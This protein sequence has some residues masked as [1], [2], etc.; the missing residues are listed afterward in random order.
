MK[1]SIEHVK[2]LIT[3]KTK[4]IIPVHL[5]GVLKSRKLNKLKNKHKLILIQDAAQ[6][7]GSQ[8]KNKDIAIFNILL[9][10]VFKQLNILLLVMADFLISKIKNYFFC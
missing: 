7:L 4:A 8:F 6:S 5:Y 3:K 2:K 10:L 1:I 9:F